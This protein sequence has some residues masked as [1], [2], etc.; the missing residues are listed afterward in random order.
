MRAN[1]CVETSSALTMKESTS[2][3]NHRDSTRTRPLFTHLRRRKAAH[4]VYHHRRCRASKYLTSRE[5]I[6]RT[7]LNPAATA[8]EVQFKTALSPPLPTRKRGGT[9]KWVLS[10]VSISEKS[11]LQG[12]F[13]FQPHLLAQFTGGATIFKVLSDATK[14]VAFYQI[15]ARGLLHGSHQV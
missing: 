12:H 10:E 4:N 6:W 8:A 2:L 1:G 13:C 14:I 5:R 15:Y 3:N 9:W 7:P 11:P